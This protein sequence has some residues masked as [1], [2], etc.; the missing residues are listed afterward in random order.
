M[1]RSGKYGKVTLEN[2]RSTTDDEPV[3]VLRAHDPIAISA[4][5]TYRFLA[6][7][8]SAPIQHLEGVTAEINAFAE[9]QAANGTREP[10]AS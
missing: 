9:W 3:F 4:M 7:A 10:S 2:P 8:Q 5:E 1:P 6:Q